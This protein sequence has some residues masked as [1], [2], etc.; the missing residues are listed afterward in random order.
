MIIIIIISFAAL[1]KGTLL[2]QPRAVTMH[3]FPTSVEGLRNLPAMPRPPSAWAQAIVNRGVLGAAAATGGVSVKTLPRFRS[4]AAANEWSTSARSSTGMGTDVVEETTVVPTA[5]DSPSSAA[6]VNTGVVALVRGSAQ[7]VVQADETVV[8]GTATLVEHGRRTDLPL[9]PGAR[10]KPLTMAAAMAAL[11]KD[12]YA[13]TSAKSM[14][15]RTKWWQRQ[16]VVH[17]GRPL[18]LT[19]L[20]LRG[21]AAVLKHGE[22][23]SAAQYM[24]AMKRWHI[25]SGHRWSLRLSLELRECIRSCERG[26]GPALQAQPLKLTP[27]LMAGGAR[28]VALKAG[29]D[30]VLV[31]AWW[32]LREIELS[33]LRRKDC[34][35][36]VGPGCGVAT[37]ELAVSKADPAA[38]GVRRTLA[39][40]CPSALCPVAATRRLLASTAGQRADAFVV[41]NLCGRPATKEEVVQEVREVARRSGTEGHVTGHSMRVTGAQRLALAGIS[42]YRIITFGRWASQAFKLYV[43]EAVLGVNGGDL[44]RVVEANTACLDFQAEL[45]KAIVA[46]QGVSKEARDDFASKMHEEPEQHWTKADIEARWL[47]FAADLAKDVRAAAEMPLPRF[48]MSEGG[49]VHIVADCRYTVCGWHWAKTQCTTIQDA[50][51]TCR[52]CAGTSLRWGVA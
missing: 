10:K 18:P 31:G 45:D 41:V 40:A 3:K 1:C 37:L 46:G 5:M 33:A 2:L 32:L 7:H 47:T 14:D 9:R 34:T 6:A 28:P 30:A 15:A 50:V 19:R 43:R 17:K 39:C 11:V 38:K 16:T 51:P 12:K 27:S 52:K 4:L 26:M 35:V 21:G 22:Y 13:A 8:E 49:V 23:R 44:S 25:R 20:K 29:I 24:Y 36:A 48:C 42:E